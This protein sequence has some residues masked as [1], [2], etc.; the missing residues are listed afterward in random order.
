MQST[1]Y[2]CDPQSISGLVVAHLAAHGGTGFATKA[3]RQ[4]HCGRL[5]RQSSPPP[6]PT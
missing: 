2:L 1:D 4:E 3:L 5:T 6:G